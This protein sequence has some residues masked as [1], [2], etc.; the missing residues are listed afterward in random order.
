MRTSLAVRALFVTLFLLLAEGY[1]LQNHLLFLYEKKESLVYTDRHGA[2]TATLQNTEGNYASY[3]KETPPRFQELLLQKEDKY[4][5]YHL[6]V[7][8]WSAFQAAL[9]QI[10]MGD[11]KASS[12]ITQQ[13]VKVLLGNESAR[14]LGNKLTEFLYT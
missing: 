11:R 8:P 9:Y 14:T 4:F 5:F 12:T 3:M 2:T 7:N 13:L 1:Y 6:G 10:G